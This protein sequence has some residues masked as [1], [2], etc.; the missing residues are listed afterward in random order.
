[1]RLVAGLGRR[2]AIDGRLAVSHGS[3]RLDP[4]HD[5]GD[6]VGARGFRVARRVGRIF[7]H[8]GNLGSPPRERVAV[9]RRRLLRR[10]GR[11]D[12]VRRRRPVVVLRRLLKDGRPVLVHERHRVLVGGHRRRAGVERVV[13]RQ[14]PGGNLVR[15][16]RRIA[17]GDVVSLNR[18]VGHVDRRA[19]IHGV[20]RRAILPGRA[21]EG[22]AVGFGRHGRVGDRRHR[23]GHAVARPVGHEL[24][25]RRHRRREDVIQAVQLPRADAVVVLRR[26]RIGS[27]DGFAV[28]DDNR[29]DGRPAVGVERHGPELRQRLHAFDRLGPLV[30]FGSVLRERRRLLNLRHFRRRDHRRRRR[31]VHHDVAVQRS[32]FQ[33]QPEAILR[34]AAPRRNLHVTVDF[35]VARHR[36]VHRRIAR[37][38][39]YVERKA[40]RRIRVDRRVVD[41]DVAVVVAQRVRRGIVRVVQRQR[42]PL[43]RQ[44]AVVLHQHLR[45]RRINRPVLERDLVVL[46]QLERLGL[47]P[48]RPHHL[49]VH[50]VR[51]AR[52]VHRQPA[53]RELALRNLDPVPGAVAQQRDRRTVR[54]RRKRF[55]Q[56]LVLHGSN[57]R[58]VRNR[59]QR[60]DA[61]FRFAP[62]VPFGRRLLER[63]GLLHR[64]RVRRHGHRRRRRRVHHDVAVQRPAFQHQPEAVLRVAARRGNLHVTVDHARPRYR[65]VH[66]RIARIPA[67]VE[68]KAARRIRVDRRVVDHDVAV[69]VAQRVRRGIVR[70]VQRQRHPL[71]RQVAVVLHQHLR[72][73]RINRPV[74]ERDLVVL[75]QL[76]R[77]GLR[78]R[79]PHHLPVHRVREARE[80]HR[81][82]AHRELALRNLDPVPG[83]VRQQ[84]DG[85]PVHR[86]RERRFQRRV[87]VARTNLGHRRDGAVLRRVGDGARGGNDFGIPPGERVNLVVLDVTGHRRC[88]RCRAGGHVGG[89][90][91]VVPDKRDRV[92][93]RR[94]GELRRVGRFAGHRRQFG[95]PAAERVGVFRR[96]HLR[97]VRVRRNRPVFHRGRVDDRAVVVL[98]RDRVAVF[99]RGERRRVRRGTR[100]RHRLRVPARECVGV[101]RRRHLRR[102]RVRRN[103][104]VFHRGRVDDRAVVVLPRDRVAVF[105]RGECRLVRRVA[106]HRHGRRVPCVERV[107]VLGRRSLGRVRVR[108]NGPVF[109]RRRVDGRAVVVLPRDRVAVLRRGEGR[110]VGR[111]T[112]HRHGSGVPGRERVGVLGRRRLGRVGM[113]RDRA[114]FDRCRVDGRAIVILPRDR[115]AVLRRGECRL[116]GCVT[117][118]RHGSGVPGRERVGVFRRRRLRRVRMRRNRAIFHRRRVDGRAIVILPR[119]RVAVLRRGECRLVGCVTRHRHG[120][121]VPGRERV[122]VFRRRRLRRVRVRRNRAIFHRRRVDGRTI[123][124]LP[125]DRVAVH[126]RGEDRVVGRVAGGRGEGIDH[127][128]AGGGAPAGERVGVLRRR[129]L[130]RRCVG[131]GRHFANPDLHR[132]EFGHAVIV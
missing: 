5:P 93:V 19:G 70:V 3:G 129:G 124:I 36:H 57:L 111:R 28:R 91:T 31:R 60:L 12:D 76:E 54:R 113:S 6:G 82:P 118:H 115:V 86:R 123:V 94:R 116:V 96:R 71:Q 107:G 88:N 97:R 67:Y 77:L 128:P 24:D 64:R 56:R 65:H 126:R 81:Q 52:E 131:V 18:R 48:R 90:R 83:A 30:P 120:S 15:S 79:R 114:I 44:V 39:A 41:H 14:G 102:V 125:R 103:R 130:R 99:R 53:H 37:V 89:G 23:H 21:F 95:R 61:A 110:L 121:G 63:R 75:Q 87:V 109:H 105:R 100:H 29:L 43:Q 2:L 45:L 9:L 132:V 38:P 25:V 16:R 51:E 17:A 49:P 117:R 104:P 112:R 35:G 55:F 1:M 78:P 13:V 7:R 80:V 20:E 40:A 98:P 127:R 74:L 26:G 84:R 101:F 119:D 58:H 47:R 50:R 85:V 4:F 27:R 106:R 59:H 10:V 108:R 72:L 42:H 34:V 92:G 11:L 22:D 122:G 66:R 69:V 46:Q 33:H 32:A 8:I 62:P 68:R 73:R